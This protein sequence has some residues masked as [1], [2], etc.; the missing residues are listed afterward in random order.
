MHGQLQ[1]DLTGTSN[2]QWRSLTLHFVCVGSD[3]LQTPA[4]LNSQVH[5][6]VELRQACYE[7]VKQMQATIQLLAMSA[8]QW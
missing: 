1:P 3:G 8:R 7:Q 5:V 2:G 6:C 4:G